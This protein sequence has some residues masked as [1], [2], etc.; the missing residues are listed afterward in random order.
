MAQDWTTTRKRCVRLCV[1]ALGVLIAAQAAL[2]W[3][4]GA[5]RMVAGALYVVAC[6]A[7][8]WVLLERAELMRNRIP[9]VW[10][11]LAWIVPAVSGFAM[12]GHLLLG[13]K[14]EQAVLG[15]GCAWVAVMSLFV[16]FSPDDADMVDNDQMTHPSEP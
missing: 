8:V 7:A 11:I 12:V 15:G 14:I 2:S 13:S 1:P 10:K 16:A 9:L 5:W 3:G 4:Q 6:L